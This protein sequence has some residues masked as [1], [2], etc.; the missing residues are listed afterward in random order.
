MN[1]ATADAAHSLGSWSEYERDRSRT[2][3][4]VHAVQ[5]R[6]DVADRKAVCGYAGSWLGRSL[7][8]ERDWNSVMRVTRCRRCT[9]ALGLD[10]M[11]GR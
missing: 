2:L 6:D 7:Q 1:T 8:P 11:T 5:I 3:L 9:S 4:C 10:W